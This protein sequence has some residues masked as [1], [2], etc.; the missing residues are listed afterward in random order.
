LKYV[1]LKFNRFSGYSGASSAA[2]SKCCFA[3]ERLPTLRIGWRSTVQQT[4]IPVRPGVIE[5]FIQF[6]RS[7]ESA[8]HSLHQAKCAESFGARELAD[9]HAEIILGRREFGVTLERWFACGNPC[10]AYSARCAALVARLGQVKAGARKLPGGFAAPRL[11]PESGLSILKSLSGNVSRT[12]R[13]RRCRSRAAAG[14][15]THIGPDTDNKQAQI[16]STQPNQTA[17]T[18]V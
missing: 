17:E 6:A 10:S 15:A 18:G 14:L 12:V 16:E 13:G 11:L 9:I 7:V 2:R 4:E 5:F 3:F 1:S 8:L